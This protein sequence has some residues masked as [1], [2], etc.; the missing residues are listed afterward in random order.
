MSF[1]R[2]PRGFLA[3][4]QPGESLQPQRAVEVPPDARF[5]ITPPMLGMG[6]E[7]LQEYFNPTVYDN[8]GNHWVELDP[9]KRKKT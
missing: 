6:R 4:R 1:G 5:I 3:P 8:I 7:R 2:S 9:D